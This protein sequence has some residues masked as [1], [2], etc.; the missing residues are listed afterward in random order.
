MNNNLI[1]SHPSNQNIIDLFSG[2]WSSKMPIFTNAESTPGNNTVMNN[3]VM[4]NTVMNNTVMITGG[5][6]FIG[7]YLVSHFLKHTDMDIIVLDGITYA[8]D[9]TRMT[10]IPSYDPKRVKVVWHDLRSPITDFVAERIGNPKWIVNCASNSHVDRSITDPAEFIMSNCTLVTNMLEFARITKPEIFLQVST[11]EVY[12]P[13]PTG[14]AH[15]EWDVHLPSNPYAASKSAQE[16][17]AVSYWRTFGVPVVITNTM[18]NFGSRQHSEKFVPM[19]VSKILRGEE[20]PIH[21]KF[22]S[23]GKFTSGSRCWL[24]A[25]T[26]ASGILHVLRQGAPKPFPIADRPGKWHI[27]GDREITNEDL[28]RIIG[29]I[30]GKEVKL[31]L[32]DFHSSRPGHDL[33]YALD[34]SLLYAAG[35]AP[36]TDF[37]N[38]LQRSVLGIAEK[39]LYP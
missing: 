26:H 28:A 12:G 30:L 21:G 29:S 8:A 22:D 36:P 35:W 15:R 37:E 9:I 18:N 27:A 16:S 14:Y 31:S 23:A 4:N 3:T 11:D 13:A 10:E 6:G 34:S 39:I 33:R 19:C 2:E 7:G 38:S 24:H 32:Q 25:D 20:I 5:A 1:T 17:I